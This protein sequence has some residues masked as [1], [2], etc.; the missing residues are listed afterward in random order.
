M[1]AAPNLPIPETATTH[2]INIGSTPPFTPSPQGIV[3]GYGDTVNFANNSGSDVTIQFAANPPGV[4]VYPPMSLL[5]P[6]GNPHG[7]VGFQVP[8]VDSAANYTIVPAGG[9]PNTGPFVIQVGE[10]PMYVIASV[11]GSSLNFA[12]SPVAVPVGVTVSEVGVLS[13]RSPDVYPLYWTPSNP[14][15][16]GIT[17]TGQTQPVKV[18][19]TAEQYG[20]SN[21]PPGG[22]IAGGGTVIIRGT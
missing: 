9:Q 21:T 16:P 8:N 3:V 10:G 7:P 20:Y 22:G 18:G 13:M 5:V 11:S 19:A 4:A 6:N 12:P 1:A 15:N 17:R 14:F 2:T